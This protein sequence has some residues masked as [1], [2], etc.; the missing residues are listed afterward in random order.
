MKLTITLTS[1]EA[2]G[3]NMTVDDVEY[4]VA[5]AHYDTSDGVMQVFG[6]RT[7]NHEE[8]CEVFAVPER[9]HHLW[10]GFAMIG[11]GGD[12]VECYSQTTPSADSLSPSCSLH[13]TLRG[14]L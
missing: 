7:D 1:A 6:N 13:R 12:M 11:P 3:N 8:S 4:V 9:D 14:T 2:E 5:A 10:Q